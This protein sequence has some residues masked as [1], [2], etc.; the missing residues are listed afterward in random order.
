MKELPMVID[1]T[2]LTEHYACREHR[3]L[4]QQEWPDGGKVAR[5]NLAR[6]FEIGLDVNWFAKEILSGLLYETY[7]E[8]LSKLYTIYAA[9]RL[10]AYE[11]KDIKDQLRK[12]QEEFRTNSRAL[13][14]KV[15]LDSIEE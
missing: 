1:K 15:L 13:L 7:N 6:A 11:G 10:T 14:L 8:E 12:L 4:F 3:E 5:K 2:W 9:T